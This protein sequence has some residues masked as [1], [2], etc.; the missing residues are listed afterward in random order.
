VKRAYGSQTLQ[1]FVLA[2]APAPQPF[3]DDQSPTTGIMDVLQAEITEVQQQRCVEA[4]TQYL[5]CLLSKYREVPV[6]FG[7]KCQLD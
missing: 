5:L 2:A 6:I 3:P 1:G 7:S 4:C